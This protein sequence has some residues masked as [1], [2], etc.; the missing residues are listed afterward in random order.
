[1]KPEWRYSCCL[2]DPGC[3]LLLA[4]TIGFWALVVWALVVWALCHLL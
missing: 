1:M 2:F 4:L 3:L